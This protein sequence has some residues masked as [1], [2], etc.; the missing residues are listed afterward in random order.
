M[1]YGELDQETETKQG[2]IAVQDITSECKYRISDDY[3]EELDKN[4]YLI[5]ERLQQVLDKKLK[6][7]AQISGQ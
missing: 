3:L 5:V 2:Y 4:P 7:D 1:E 6:P